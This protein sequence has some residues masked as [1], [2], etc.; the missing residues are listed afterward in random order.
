[1]SFKLLN[2]LPDSYRD[3][4]QLLQLQSTIMSE[5]E[6]EVKQ[7]AVM[8]ATPANLEILSQSGVKIPSS[9]DGVPLNANAIII[10]VTA[11][12]AAGAKKAVEKAKET[13]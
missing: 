2:V 1:M 4:V 5:A 8:M 7:C 12:S 9:V 3:S 11:E 13:I 10:S 6:G